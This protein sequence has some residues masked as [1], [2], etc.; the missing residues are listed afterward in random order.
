MIRRGLLFI[1]LATELSAPASLQAQGVA[2]FRLV[3]GDHV[4][5]LGNALIEHE[6]F[7]GYLEGNL[8]RHFSGAK[9]RSAC[10]PMM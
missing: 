1:M 3:D 6:R 8:R 4:V 10:P 9:I 2:P 7:H 5:L